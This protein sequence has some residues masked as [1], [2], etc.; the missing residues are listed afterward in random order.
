L[1]LATLWELLGA[2]QVAT[3]LPELRRKQERY[4]LI[5]M[6]VSIGM[7]VAAVIENEL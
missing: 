2:R 4:G 7:G 6:C 1:H 5:S 3:L